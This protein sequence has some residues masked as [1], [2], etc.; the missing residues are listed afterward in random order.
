MRAWPI[1]CTRT[2]SY[3]LLVLLPPLLESGDQLQQIGHFKACMTEIYLHIDARMADYQVTSY[4]TLV[5]KM[6]IALENDR[7]AIA[8]ALAT[9]P[10]R[11]GLGRRW[12]AIKN[13]L[14]LQDVLVSEACVPLLEGCVY[15]LSD[16]G[17]VWI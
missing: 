2:R 14:S 16:Y 10:P 7:V 9:T 17:C 15:T 12:C 6:P 8:A 3:S 1:N 11:P 5:A 4:S 13:T